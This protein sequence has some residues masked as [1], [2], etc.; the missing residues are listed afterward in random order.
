MSIVVYDVPIRFIDKIGPASPLE[1]EH[2]WKHILKLFAP[3]RSEDTLKAF[4]DFRNK[5]QNV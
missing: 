1:R 5:Q 4:N 3:Y 2:Y